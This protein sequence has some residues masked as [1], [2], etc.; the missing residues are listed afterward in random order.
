MGV[1]DLLASS[2]MCLWFGNLSSLPHGLLH[3]AADRK[4]NGFPGAGDPAGQPQTEAIFF[5]QPHLGSGIASLLTYSVG[6]IDQLQTRRGLHGVGMSG[7]WGL[8]RQPSWRLSTMLF[9]EL[10]LYVNEKCLLL[11]RK[12]YLKICF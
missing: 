9:Q 2:P 6:H 4:A 1:E 12:F 8:S 3:S 10:S 7:N 11:K 5:L